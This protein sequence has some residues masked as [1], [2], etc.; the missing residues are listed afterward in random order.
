MGDTLAS[1]LGILSTTAPVLIT[2][3]KTVPP[4]TNG[5]ISRL[6][7]LASVGGGS[8][9]GLAFAISLITE[10]T[11]CREQ[12]AE[13]LKILTAYGC[14]AGFIGSLVC[15]ANYFQIT[16]LPEAVYEPKLDSLMG[17]TIQRTCYSSTAKLVLQ[18]GSVPHFGDDI[19][20][21]SG[22]DLLTNNQVCHL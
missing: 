14:L 8:L 7:T 6:G 5:A 12:W 16:A 19:K 3:L 18:D 20:I 11:V 17:A 1:E 22:A 13:T 9:I 15:V 10:N 4:G 21:I 2:S